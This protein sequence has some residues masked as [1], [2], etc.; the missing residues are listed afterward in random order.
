MTQ[1]QDLDEIESCQCFFSL[2]IKLKKKTNKF[3]KMQNLLLCL[4][5]K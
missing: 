3:L 1:S 5:L 4:L 2:W